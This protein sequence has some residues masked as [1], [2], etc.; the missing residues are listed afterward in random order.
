MGKKAQWLK[1]GREG[2]AAAV[3][4]DGGLD[5]WATGLAKRAMPKTMQVLERAGRELKEN[6]QANW[7]VARP[8]KRHPGKRSKGSRQGWYSK[9][10]I[11][12]EGPRLIVGN[13][14]TGDLGVPYT[15]YVTYPSVQSDPNYYEG[16]YKGGPEKS[17]FPVRDHLFAPMMKMRE[18]I[19]KEIMEEVTR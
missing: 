6:V 11:T 7:P 3:R 2:R 5:E 18:R 4:V 8:D 17:S 13:T 19:A 15:L 16:P 1:S 9:V 14:V 12:K 10:E